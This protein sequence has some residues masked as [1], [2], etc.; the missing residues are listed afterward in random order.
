MNFRLRCFGLHMLLSLV[1]AALA[2]SLVFLVWYPSP[3]DLA[4]GVTSIFLLLLG[5]DVVL[6]PLL[7][8]LVAKKGKKTLKMDLLI[9]VVVQIAALAYGLYIV[10]QGRPVWLVYDSGKF[11]LVQAYE[12]IGLDG[13]DVLPA[14]QQLSY[15]GPVW[16]AASPAGDFTPRENLPLQDQ[17]LRAEYL[18]EYHQK[19]VVFEDRAIPLQILHRF[20][21]P[22][23]TGEILKNYPKADAYIPLQA[24]KRPLTVLVNKTTGESVAIVELSPW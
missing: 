19:A 23:L 1:V 24:K 12:V 2:L 3:L 13:K 21:N 6:G 15:S 14:F 16:A 8:L 20:N 5:V 9:I 4:L 11:E 22:E 17:Y 7:T 10:A 18:V